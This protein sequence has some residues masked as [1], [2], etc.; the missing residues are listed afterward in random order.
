MQVHKKA[1][2]SPDGEYFAFADCQGLLKIWETSSNT[3]K[4]QHALLSSVNFS[5]SSLTWGPSIKVSKGYSVIYQFR[6][7]K[8]LVFKFCMSAYLKTVLGMPG[9][10]I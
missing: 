2:F 5:C 6:D 1:V 8:N 7:L 9:E 10:G 3:V 4:K